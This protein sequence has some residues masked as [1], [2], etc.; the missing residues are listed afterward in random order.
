MKKGNIVNLTGARLRKKPA[1]TPEEIAQAAIRLIL[2]KV[3]PTVIEP[4]GFASGGDM[5]T[6]LTDNFEDCEDHN[7]SNK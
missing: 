7:E 2:D 4:Q 6:I 1:R 5:T 3:P